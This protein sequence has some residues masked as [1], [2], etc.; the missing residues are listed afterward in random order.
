MRR[1]TETLNRLGGIFWN[2]PRAAFGSIGQPL[3]GTG[4]KKGR[5]MSLLDA[6]LTVHAYAKSNQ[7]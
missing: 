6:A 1:A 5:L 4:G 3:E 7:R 2:G